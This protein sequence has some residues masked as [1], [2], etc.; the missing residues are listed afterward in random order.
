MI[1]WWL[2]SIFPGV[3][4]AVVSQL[5][6]HEG[7]TPASREFERHPSVP[8]LIYGPSG[9]FLAWFS[10]HRHHMLLARFRPVRAEYRP[11]SPFSLNYSGPW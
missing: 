7:L 3:V 6:N 5:T 11:A 4:N 2:F 1:S 8:N 10:I 9:L